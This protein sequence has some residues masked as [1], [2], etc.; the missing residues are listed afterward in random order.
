M[1]DI[2]PI[3]IASLLDTSPESIQEIFDADPAL[4]PDVNLDR[5]VAEIRRRT[6]IAKAEAAAEAAAPKTPSGRKRKADPL[7]DAAMASIADKPID[8]LS[9]DD[10]GDV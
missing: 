5:L 7:I 2:G 8:E 3:P 6:D 1:T 4:A 10:L 9:L